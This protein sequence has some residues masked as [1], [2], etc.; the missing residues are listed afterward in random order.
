MVNKKCGCIICVIIRKWLCCADACKLTLEPNTAHA[1]LSLTADNTRMSLLTEDQPCLDHRQ[2]LEYVKQALCNETL[3]G[4]CYWEVEWGGW[5]SIAVA[6]K[7]IRKRGHRKDCRFG[8]SKKSWSLELKDIFGH[9]TV[10]H[11]S[12]RIAGELSRGNRVGVYVDFPAGILSFYTLS[13]DTHT[14]TRIHTFHTTFTEPL[15]AG[16]GLKD[17]NSSISIIHF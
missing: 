9:Y 7:S 14:L 12:K 6:Y 8:Y 11:N 4:R 5:A 2:R 1:D 17:V 15:F 10:V 3:S 13:F 16:F